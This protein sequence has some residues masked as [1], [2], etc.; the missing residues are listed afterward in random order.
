MLRLLA[1]VLMLP[2]MAGLLAHGAQAHSAAEAGGRKPLQPDRLARVQAVGLLRAC[3]WPEY[4]GISFRDPRS[5]QLNGLEIDNAR[6]L[7]RA[8]GVEVVFVDSAFSRLADDLLSDR[9][10]IATFAIGITPERQQRL[11]FT[12][13]HLASDIYAI[14]ARSNRRVQQW[15]DIDRPGVVVVV[16]KG[17]LHETVMRERLRMA[18]L[19]VVDSRAAREQEVQSGR[20]DVFMTDYPFSRHFLDQ[21]DWARLISPPQRYH[22]TPYGW[23]M[24][25][26]DDRF[27]ARVDQVLAAMLSDGRV[28]ANARRHGLE[29]L[30]A[31]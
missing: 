7:G 20:A 13:A 27:H 6:E 24:A 22:V 26:G 10:D 1:F 18:E 28:L 12:R 25:P 19:R 31:R 17:T 29:P 30:V 2:L 21:R 15:A 14:G 8:L 16:A 5:Q 4:Y 23:A 9:C 3:V 11:R